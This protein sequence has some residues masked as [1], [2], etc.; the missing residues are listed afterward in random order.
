MKKIIF[1]IMAAICLFGLSGCYF[2][3]EELV[4]S[5]V[6]FYDLEG[7]EIPGE[8]INYFDH[9][10]NDT[11]LRLSSD[12]KPLNS[13]APIENF[14]CATIEDGTSIEVVMKFQKRVNKEFV[15]LTLIRQ[16]DGSSLIELINGIEEIDEYIYVTYVVENITTDNNLYEVSEWTDQEG[17]KHYFGTRGGNTYIRGFYFNLASQIIPS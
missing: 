3:N 12:L 10:F 11:S 2:H 5:D 4:F 1:I 17:G 9:V 6:K 15:S 14:Y 8:Y 13:A 7:N 16:N